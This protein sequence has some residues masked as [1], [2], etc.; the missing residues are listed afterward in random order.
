MWILKVK[1]AQYVLWLQQRFDLVISDMHDGLPLK[2]C[3][4]TWIIF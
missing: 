3:V 4:D 1:Y 2:G